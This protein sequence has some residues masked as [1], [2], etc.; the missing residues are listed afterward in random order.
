MSVLNNPNTLL[1]K[2]VIPWVVTPCYL[3]GGHHHSKEN[4]ASTFAIE[5]NMVRVR[6]GYTQRCKEMGTQIHG[7]GKET[8]LRRGQ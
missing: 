1:S 2:T 5:M 7:R 3:V 8:E 4:A 6:L